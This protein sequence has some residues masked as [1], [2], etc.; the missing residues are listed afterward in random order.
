MTPINF[1]EK[2]HW[3]QKV[4]KTC[5]YFAA[6]LSAFDDVTLRINI[7]YEAAFPLEALS[8]IY[9]EHAWFTARFAMPT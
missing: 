2:T 5:C 1:A 3:S 6:Q 4:F 7:K 9:V 8:T